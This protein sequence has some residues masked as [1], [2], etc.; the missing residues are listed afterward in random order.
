MPQAELFKCKI[1]MCCLK[2]NYLS[3][4]ILR[5]MFNL[6]AKMYLILYMMGTRTQNQEDSYDSIQEKYCNH[7]THQPLKTY[8]LTHKLL[9]FVTKEQ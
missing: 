7:L 2:C 4:A 9:C 6:L 8:K 1:Q 5:E 3:E